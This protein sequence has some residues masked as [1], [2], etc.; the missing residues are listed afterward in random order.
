MDYTCEIDDSFITEIC[1]ISYMA[2]IHRMCYCTV[3]VCACN[4][5]LAVI[6]SVQSSL[7]SKSTLTHK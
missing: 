3:R 1:V 5:G 6:I 7:L 4:E 2:Y